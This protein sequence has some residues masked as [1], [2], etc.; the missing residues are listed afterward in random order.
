MYAEKICRPNIS[1]PLRSHEL[2]H[3]VASR[4]YSFLHISYSCLHISPLDGDKGKTKGCNGVGVRGELLAAKV[5]PNAH[6]LC[7]CI[8][9]TCYLL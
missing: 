8:T 6:L 5:I 1:K 9:A 3:I 7:G 2:Q 4:S